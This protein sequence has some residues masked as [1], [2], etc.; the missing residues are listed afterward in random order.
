MLIGPEHKVT[1]GSIGIQFQAAQSSAVGRMYGFANGGVLVGSVTAG[2]P[3]SKAGLLSGDV[4]VA[5][6]G[7]PIKDGDELV[8]I[9]SAKRPGSTVKLTYLRGGKR[10]TADVGIA[11]RAKLFADLDNPGGDDNSPDQTDVGQNKLGITVQPTS[12]QVAGK[13]GIKGGVTITAVKPGSF[14]DTINLPQGVVITEINRKPVT[15]EASYRAI[16]TAL[17]SGEDVVFVVRDPRSQAGG[18]TYIGGTLP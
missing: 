18:N 4:I 10:E 9:I 15:D 3:A 17:K 11:D 5:V 1:R 2:G 12:Q 7:A 8:A 14:A 6:D 16:V 13:L